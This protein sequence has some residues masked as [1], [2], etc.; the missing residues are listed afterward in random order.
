[1]HFVIP[2]AYKASA[3]FEI[4]SPSMESLLNYCKQDIKQTLRNQ[5]E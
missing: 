1:M 2:T 5:Y 3:N 4:N